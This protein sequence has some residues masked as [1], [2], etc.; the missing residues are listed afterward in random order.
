MLVRPSGEL[1]GSWERPEEEPRMPRRQLTD[2]IVRSLT[3]PAEGQKVVYDTIVP[4]F[5]LRLAAGGA[6]TWV[7]RYKIRGRSRWFTLGTYPL[8]SL[9][10]ARKKAKE[11]LAKVVQ[12]E[13]PASE[14][15]AANEAITFG[16]LT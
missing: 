1:W 9:A 3:A 13:D 14:R 8:I 15:R 7:V 4:R 16:E 11:A 6:R 12:G 10:D 2:P 5:G